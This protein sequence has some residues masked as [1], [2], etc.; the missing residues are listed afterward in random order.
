MH[1]A[2]VSKI[3]DV[4]H[5][6]ELHHALAY[7]RT[8][9]SGAT[10]AGIRAS[11]GLLRPDDSRVDL[12]RAWSKRFDLLPYGLDTSSDATLVVLASAAAMNDAG[13]RYRNCLASRIS[14]V[15]LGTHLFVEYRP[16]S[17]SEPG[18]IAELRRIERG[19]FLENL[20]GVG[21]TRVRA[22][23]ANLV[24]RKLAACGVALLDHAPASPEMI[25]A[26]AGML[27]A[28]PLGLPDNNAWGEEVIDAADHP[29]R[30]LD[31]A[32]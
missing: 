16:I 22:D 21:N 4:E 17:R 11:L 10:D 8:Y 23:R 24:R 3:H 25:H 29:E 31:E 9:C 7:I 18:V 20:Y 30:A 12:V 15:I 26:V 5:V 6:P 1:P 19:F 2:L 27:G 14:D 28:W 13:R 32:A